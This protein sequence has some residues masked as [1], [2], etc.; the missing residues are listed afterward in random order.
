MQ[1]L[2]LVEGNQRRDFA[3]IVWQIAERRGCNEFVVRYDCGHSLRAEVSAPHLPSTKDYGTHE[4]DRSRYVQ[5]C[6]HVLTRHPADIQVQVTVP[7]GR[8]RHCQRGQRQTLVCGP[9]HTDLREPAAPGLVAKTLGRGPLDALTHAKRVELPMTAHSFLATI[10]Q[11][12]KMPETANLHPLAGAQEAVLEMPWASKPMMPKEEIHQ[13]TRKEIEDDVESML[14]RYICCSAILLFVFSGESFYHLVTNL[15]PIQQEADGTFKEIE[16]IGLD[17]LT[18][19]LVVLSNL[20]SLS[21]LEMRVANCTWIMSTLTYAVHKAAG[22]GE[23]ADGTDAIGSSGGYVWSGIVHPVWVGILIGFTPLLCVFEFM[24]TMPRFVMLNVMFTGIRCLILQPGRLLMSLLS[25]ILVFLTR[26]LFS[27]P[28]VL[29]TTVPTANPLLGAAFICISLA[30]ITSPVPLLLLARDLWNTTSN[31]G[32]VRRCRRAAAGNKTL[33]KA[34]DRLPF[35]ASRSR[36]SGRGSRDPK[37]DCKGDRPSRSDS[38]KGD[39]LQG[40]DDK[41][42]SAFAPPCFVCLDKPSRYILEPCGHRVV[43]GD[44]AVQLVDAAA[45]TRTATEAD[46]GGDRGGNCPSCTMAINRAMRIFP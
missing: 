16:Y 3:D 38:G 18:P 21:G 40:K 37:K 22:P 15:M 42:S 2:S 10:G 23:A 7:E 8:C 12:C 9:V 41:G 43:C 33:N 35:G 29:V 45:R 25:S 20:T 36:G 5:H 46:R 14:L 28:A 27:P 31:L 26:S 39:K 4:A 24:I 11:V 32:L 13:W 19:E 30:A 6:L 17:Q 1:E 34:L 44:C